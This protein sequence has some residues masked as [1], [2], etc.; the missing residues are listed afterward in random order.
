MKKKLSVILFLILFTSLS[1]SKDK[2]EDLSPVSAI[3][4]FP[5]NNTDC[6]E[7]NIIS[8]T[9][10]E[11]TFRWNSSENTDNYLLKI[12]L[13]EDSIIQ[14][15]NTT[16]PQATAV[17]E[18]GKTYNWQVISQKNT[19][20][21]DGNSSIWS[22]YNSGVASE[23]NIPFQAELISPEQDENILAGQITL[24]WIS[25]DLNNDITENHILMDNYYP[26]TSII[27]ISSGDSFDILVQPFNIY[28]WQ[29]VTNDQSGSKSF[30]N[31]F[32]FNV[33]AA[34]EIDGGDSGTSTQTS[35]TN[36]NLI[37]DGTMDNI[38]AWKYKK[39]WTNS[40]N[41]VNH[42][43]VDGEF[44]F[45]GVQGVNFSNAILWQEVSI[46]EGVSYNFD[47][48]LRSGGTSNSWLEIYFGT[49]PVEGVSGDEYV[50][51][52]AQVFVKSFGD[53]ENC[54]VNSFE[55][56]IFEI[57]STGCPIPSTSLLDINGNVIFSNSN[58]TSNSTIFIGIKA[59][60]YD[61]FF[62]TGIFLDNISL[63]VN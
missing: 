1:C 42:G 13:V 12:I 47:A 56:S 2:I 32:S 19:S 27:G 44:A 53:G 55:G 23:N 25:S 45:R 63:T 16:L 15:I 3:L 18:R 49:D 38:G 7:G 51:N 60:N 5:E 10:S 57:A 31:I 43:F 59:G 54:G 35:V 14:I 41:E 9:K 20:L 48:Y 52:G 17:L 40:D 36:N 46:E 8:S 28:Y 62:G 29:I 11:V 30:S 4:I 34:S 33:G 39:L 26:P 61:G 50:S 37:L 24:N 6:N 22:F 58:I 21:V